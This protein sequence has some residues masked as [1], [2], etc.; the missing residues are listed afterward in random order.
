MFEQAQV[1]VE[2][3]LKDAHHAQKIA[4]DVGAN[5]PSLDLAESNLQELRSKHGAGID[6]S[7][8]YGIIREK[9]SLPFAKQ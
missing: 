8:V 7:A 5:L 2:M 1:P 9:C 3:A 4:N 6:S